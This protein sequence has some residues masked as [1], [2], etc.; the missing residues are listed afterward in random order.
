MGAQEERSGGVSPRARRQDSGRYRSLVENAIEGVFQTTPDGRILTANPALVEML[1]YH[2]EDELLAVNVAEDLYFDP[3]ER[4]RIAAKLTRDGEV[5][6]EEIVL[7]TRDGNRLIVLE[8]SRG[9][10]DRQGNITHFEGTLTNITAWRD[11]ENLF[12]TLAENT[13]VGIFIAQDNRFIFVNPTFIEMTGYSEQELL[14]TG[15]I[16]MLQ[17]SERHEALQNAIDMMSG[18]RREAYEQRFVTRSGELR[19]TLATISLISYRGRPATLGNFIDVTERKQDRDLLETLAASS[20]VAIYIV[21]DERFKFV[22]PQVLR[23]TG[24]AQAELLSVHPLDVVLP[25]DRDLVWASAESLLKGEERRPYEHRVVSTTGDVRWVMDTFTPIIFEGRPAVLGNSIDITERK[26]AE[27]QLA[28]QAFYDSLTDLPNRALFMQRLEHA[29]VA[30]RR[31]RKP[32]AVM[33]LDLDDFKDV[34]D[35][36]GHAAGDT[37]LAKLGERLTSCVRPTDTVARIGGDEFTVLLD[38]PNTTADA[39]A[40]A[41]RIVHELDRPFEIDGHEVRVAA[42]IGLAFSEPGRHSAADLLR[43]ADVAL[44]HAKSAGKARYVVFN[45]ERRAA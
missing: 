6:N 18:K 16:Q 14:Q 33:F 7:R 25:E 11:A 30:S 38:A 45:Q 15:P 17:E 22:N 8:N 10:R 31:H 24:R 41:A 1:G 32:V 13:P 20:P 28:R 27:E 34:N 12:R 43:E 2:S 4:G 26:L 9:V 42:S 37:L 39:T 21:Q 23:L 35:T 44:Y 40:V 5:R 3:G 19:W 29:L 36:L